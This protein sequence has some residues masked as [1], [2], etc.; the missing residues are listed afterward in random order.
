MATKICLKCEPRAGMN[1][2]KGEVTQE[3]NNDTEAAQ[4]TE[5]TCPYCGHKETETIPFES[6]GGTFNSGVAQG[7]ASTDEP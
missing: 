6:T 2:M 1:F 4:I 7:P 3:Y 5:W